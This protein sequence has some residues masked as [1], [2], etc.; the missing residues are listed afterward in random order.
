MNPAMKIRGNLLS[1]ADSSRKAAK[2]AKLE[3]SE[4]LFRKLRAFA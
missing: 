1:K 2:N 4:S 3:I